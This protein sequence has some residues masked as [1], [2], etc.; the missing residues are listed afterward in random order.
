MPE[1]RG[2]NELVKVDVF[3]KLDLTEGM[4]VADLGC[5]NLG[6][7]AMSAAR[8]VGRKGTVYAVDILKSVLN[9][10]GNLAR[11]QGFDNVKIIWSNLEIVGATKIPVASVDIAL[12][13]NV[14]FQSTDDAMVLKEAARL[15]KRGGK[16]MIIDWTKIASPF[17]PPIADRTN[18][19][20]IKSMAQA[21]GFKLIEEFEAGPYHY[22]LI[23][24]KI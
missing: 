5:G 23:F 15:T 20:E 18:P 14:L 16:L 4:T 17:G 13:H 11:Q 6:Y 24:I 19:T 22:G 12:L 3:K 1:G 21:A 7:F 9:S 10:V 2:A 8:I